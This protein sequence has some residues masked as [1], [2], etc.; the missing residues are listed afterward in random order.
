[1]KTLTL[2]ESVNW[3]EAI[4]LTADPCSKLI[5]LPG[6]EGLVF[7]VRWPELLPYQVPYFANLFLPGDSSKI[8]ECLFLLADNGAS[9]ELNF[10]LACGMLGILRASH[11]E[12]RGLLESPAYLL[13]GDDSVEARMLL[14]MAIL[15]SWDCYVVPQH[16]RYFIWIDDDD[17]ADVRC[18]NRQDYDALVARFTHFGVIPEEAPG[19]GANN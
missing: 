15:F 16:G 3:I 17:A 12:N 6:E 8:D 19:I 2:L 18:R 4:G 1:M 9:G 13:S 14:T 5:S 10:E 7:T 11:G